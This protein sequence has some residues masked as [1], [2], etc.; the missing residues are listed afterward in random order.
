MTLAA[1]TRL[2]PHAV[3]A[4]LLDSGVR[5]VSTLLACSILAVALPACRAKE[6][7]PDIPKLMTELRGSDPQASGQAR[8][9]LLQLGEP[10]VPALAEM[11][12][13]GTPADRIAAANTLWG[14][15]QRAR[16]AVPDL[17]ET[18][19]DADPELRVAAAMALQNMGDA[20]APAVPSLTKAISDRDLRVRQT[21]VKA[22]GAIGPSA[23]AALPALTRV[24]RRGSWPEAE[25]AVRSIR[26]LE[27]GA[28]VE[29]GP[30]EP[31]QP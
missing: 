25:E 21:A 27:P 26:G 12:R 4:P 11:L 5:A 7:K 15:G 31:E 2:G 3:L 29:L 30:A 22:L 16:A 20:A 10:A 18:L 6:E 13:S 17:A 14:M 28:L 8:L 24:L 1:R 9:K 19:A 23:R